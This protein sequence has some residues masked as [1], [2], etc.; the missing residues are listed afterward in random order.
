MEHFR[1]TGYIRKYAIRLLNGPRPGKL[2]RRRLSYG[3]QLL[4]ILTTISAATGYP[5]SVRLEPE[6]WKSLQDLPVPTNRDVPPF[7]YITGGA[8]DALRLTI[9]LFWNRFV[10]PAG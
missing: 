6:I 4:G 10:R 2:R 9:A 8:G 5:W 7:G 1:T 3:Q